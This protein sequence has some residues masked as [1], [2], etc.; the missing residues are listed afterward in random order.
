MLGRH[1]RDTAPSILNLCTTCRWV[2]NL[3]I[4]PPQEALISMGGGNAWAPQLVLMLRKKKASIAPTRN[5]AMISWPFSLRP[6]HRIDWARTGWLTSTGVGRI[7][8]EDVGVKWGTILAVSWSNRGEN[9]L[10]SGQRCRWPRLN[11]EPLKWKA[12]VPT[13][14]T[15]FGMNII[16]H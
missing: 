13:P 11:P 10:Q 8:W 6:N 12:G 5:W 3:T 16:G 14:H 7:L 15:T 4:P 2:T 9:Y 1:S